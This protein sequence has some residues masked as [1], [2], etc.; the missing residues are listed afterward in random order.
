[1]LRGEEDT[2]WLWRWRR[3]GPGVCLIDGRVDIRDWGM[4]TMMWRV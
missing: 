2:W 1:M 4:L 3:C